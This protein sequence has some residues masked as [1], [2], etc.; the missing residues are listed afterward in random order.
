MMSQ[1]R[2]TDDCPFIL[3]KVKGGLY[4]INSRYIA[5]ILQLPKY[6][7]AADAIAHVTG[8]FSHRG[9]VVEMFDIRSALGFPTLNVE[10]EAFAQM[11]EDR[12]Q[13]H[14]NWVKELERSLQAGEKFGLATDPHKCAFGKWYDHYQFENDATAFHMRKIEEPH[15]R[16]HQAAEAAEQC[17]RQCASCTREEC[18][19]SI[20]KRVKEESVQQ[21]I[22]LLDE[23]KEM[24]HSTVYNEM[25]L[26][27]RGTG[28]GLVVDE[29]L[30]VAML[31]PAEGQDV[32][33]VLHDATMITGIRQGSR[34][35]ELIP[36]LNLTALLHE[37]RGAHAGVGNIS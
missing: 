36:E 23:A 31:A 8:M 22:H 19:K 9:A 30:D 4:C 32:M 18:L 15:L 35:S 5:T 3:F 14:I 25:V 28:V 13:D 1:N 2:E 17:S 16:L 6:Q 29:V 33:H 24:F 12:K 37:Y 11:L 10:Y 7:S 21:I 34:D 27:V 26:L 20:L